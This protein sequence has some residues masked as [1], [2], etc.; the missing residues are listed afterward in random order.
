[1]AALPVPERGGSIDDLRPFINVEHEADFKL[2]VA[3]VL[4]SLRPTGPFAHL[5]LLGEQ[6]SA[7]ST[8]ARIIRSLVD[9][10]FSPLRAEPTSERDLAIAGSNVWMP[11]WDN[12]S[13]MQTWMSDALCRLSTGGGFSTRALAL[14]TDADEK[15]FQLMRPAILTGIGDV[16]VRGDLLDRMIIM[17]LPR[18]TANRMAEDELW[19][20]FYDY[21]PFILG[22]L[23][24]AVS[25]AIK[26]IDKVRLP[27]LPRLADFAKWVT[28]GETA[29]GWEPGTCVDAFFANQDESNIV[30]LEGS[31]VALTIME[32][33]KGKGWSG[34]ATD[35]LAT[36]VNKA[37]AQGVMFGIPKTPAGM[38]SALNKLKPNLRRAGVD[39]E[40][41]REGKESKRMIYITESSKSVGG[42]GTVGDGR[43][44]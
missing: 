6:G 33:A 11:V 37:R 22:A 26:N 1:M 40:F 18:L 21:R 15:T 16:A 39:V 19:P 41:A 34:T 36:V 10:N 24:D 3:F 20:N 5:E 31:A 35:P 7:K 14:Y 12:M 38:R 9:P 30:V 44:A 28:A 27:R 25:M 43:A 4:G 42:V 17:R 8:T 13:H 23:L 2:V 32:L 29:F